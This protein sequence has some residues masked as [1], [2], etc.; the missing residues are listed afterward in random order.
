MYIQEIIRAADSIQ[1]VVNSFETSVLGSGGITQFA[2]RSGLQQQAA[3]PV[4]SE[5][6]VRTFASASRTRMN[7]DR[8]VEPT[9]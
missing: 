1:S 8:E 6:E 4:S 2:N 5:Q 7:V 3:W 9:K